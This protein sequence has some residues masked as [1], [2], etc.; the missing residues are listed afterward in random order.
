MVSIGERLRKARLDQGLSLADVVT[1]TRIR[2]TYLDAIE[3]GDLKCLPGV[4]FYKSFIRQYAQA[5]G[6]EEGQ[7]ATEIDKVLENERETKVP[8]QG[9]YPYVQDVPPLRR[10]SRLRLSRTFATFVVMVA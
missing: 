7:F 6:F 8:G 3:R 10:H 1:R 4:F 2:A 5:L 9:L